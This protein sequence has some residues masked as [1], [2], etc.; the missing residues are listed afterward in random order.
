MWKMLKKLFGGI[1]LSW[2]K[3]ILFAVVIGVYAGV[4]FSLPFTL[5]T[6]FADIG[7]QYE[8][9]ILFAILIMVNSKSPM[10]SALKCLVF[11]AISKPI[12][13]L[14]QIPFGRESFDFIR[15]VLYGGWIFIAL[16]AIPL[17]YVGYYIKKRNIWSILILSPMFILLAFSG[18]DYLR[19]AI[20][21][22]PHHLLSAVFCFAAIILIA[23]GIFGERNL[24]IISLSFVGLFLTIYL[25]FFGGIIAHRVSV[26]LEEYGI[27]LNEN[28]YISHASYYPAG[29][30]EIVKDENGKYKLNIE[31]YR[32][33]KYQFTVAEENEQ[34][35]SETC[36]NVECGF[37]AI[38]HFALSRVDS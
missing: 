36:C 26:D 6:S 23:F 20:N 29:D 11:F 18:L 9:W 16:L 7:F 35:E 12:I 10:D 32:N 24:R 17:G 13:Y 14:V 19:Q 1:D 5:N 37:D 27:I 38:G 8:W 4:M 34:G 2:K 3:L 28:S 22:F 30:G 21:Y 25:L 15:L 31:G 33:G